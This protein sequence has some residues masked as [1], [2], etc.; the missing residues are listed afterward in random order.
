MSR[1]A[2][3]IVTTTDL[4]MVMRE[5][6][7]NAYAEIRKAVRDKI[8]EIGYTNAEYDLDITQERNGTNNS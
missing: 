4:V 3:E 6:T 2:C 8:R 5:I 7:F 1:V